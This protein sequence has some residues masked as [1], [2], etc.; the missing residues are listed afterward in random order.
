MRWPRI[1]CGLPRSLAATVIGCSLLFFNFSQRKLNSGRW[2][3]TPLCRTAPSLCI[4]Q[5][6]SKSRVATSDGQTALPL[7]RPVGEMW[8]RKW[9]K[10]SS[11]VFPRHFFVG[12][13][14]KRE[15][16][17]GRR[18]QVWCSGE[19]GGW[20][21]FVRC[22][23]Q[24]SPS[25]VVE[26]SYQRRHPSRRRRRRHPLIGHPTENGAINTPVVDATGANEIRRRRRGRRRGRGERNGAIANTRAA[27][28]RGSLWSLNRLRRWSSRS[29]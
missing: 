9:K 6:S 28:P 19:G 11:L 10:Q 29:R 16:G 20:S 23:V 12:W 22:P 21:P 24:P 5:F 3:A 1:V 7:V 14:R 17:G 13:A 25:S 8:A 26:T 4:L 15:K 2:R 18:Q 27:R